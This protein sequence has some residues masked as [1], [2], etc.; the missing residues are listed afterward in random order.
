LLVPSY[1]YILSNYSFADEFFVG[2]ANNAIELIFFYFVGKNIWE[3]AVYL[4]PLLVLNDH[5]ATY[6][7][8][9]CQT[10]LNAFLIF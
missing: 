6:L 3:G 8:L 4:N 9:A 10:H 5:I 7:G 2:T 1:S